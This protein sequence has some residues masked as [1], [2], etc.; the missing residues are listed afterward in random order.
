[1]TDTRFPGRWLG[2]TALVL[3]PLLLLAGVLLRAGRPFFFPAQ[4]QAY[5]DHPA[6]MTASYSCFLAGVVLLWPAVLV[7]AQH[8]GRE[9]PMWA[10]WGG[11]MAVFGLFAR[12]FHAGVD[13]LAFRLAADRGPEEATRA[14]AD[15]YGAW[16]LM[17]VFSVAIMAGWIVL[18]VGAVRSKTFGWFRAAALAAAALLPLGVLKGTTPMSIVAVCGL[19]IALAPLGVQVLREGPVPRLRTLLGRVAGILLLLA[20]MAFAGTLG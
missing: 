19:V 7:L 20:A 12:A 5:A 17:S 18:A 13:H 11:S 15:A 14:V 4:L 10:L 8:V 16:H 3:G 9:R 2:G 6:L 1:M